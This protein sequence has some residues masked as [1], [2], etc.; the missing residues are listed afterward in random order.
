MVD[1][2]ALGMRLTTLSAQKPAGSGASYT[3]TTWGKTRQWVTTINRSIDFHRRSINGS[4][5]TPKQTHLVIIDV[6]HSRAIVER[7]V[8]LQRRVN[9]FVGSV[10]WGQRNGPK[11][12]EAKHPATHTGRTLCW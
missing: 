3:V 5:T 10:K 4:Q 6:D 1:F 8:D 7:L 2:V 12:P 11:R 9:G